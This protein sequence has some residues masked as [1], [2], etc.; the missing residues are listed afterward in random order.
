MKKFL[1]SFLKAILPKK[2]LSLGRKY[3]SDKEMVL[4]PKYR[5]EVKH[6]SGARIVAN[7][8]ELLGYLPEGGVVAELG[9]D[10]G[11]FSQQI[12]ENCKPEKLHLIDVWASERFN[13][14]K[15]LN[16]SRT[17]KEKIDNGSVII[18]RKLSTEVVSDF[19]DF[20]FDW[21]YIDTDH[22]Y[23]NT[24][25]ELRVFAQKV[26]IGGYIAGHDYSMGNWL[27][28][29]KFGVIEA[30][31]EFCV[32]EG[33]KLVFLTADYTENPSFVITRIVEN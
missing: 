26:K 15:A 27:T 23:E 11:L 31:A 19:D 22:T 28:G 25:L 12:I 33:W 2:L 32:T 13:E 21:I 4:W 5:L 3:L 9:V 8:I 29:T 16:V 17:F 20:Y 24:L 1:K 7:R 6:T 10:K 18:N 14:Q 30:V